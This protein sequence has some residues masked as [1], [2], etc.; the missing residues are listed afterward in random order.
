MALQDLLDPRGQPPHRL[1]KILAVEEKAFRFSR[2]TLTNYGNVA[3]VVVLDALRRA[4]D[5]GEVRRG[6]RAL[7][8]AFGPGITAAMAVG[9]W[10][11]DPPT[12]PSEYSRLSGATTA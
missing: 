6:D 4:F 12:A 2:A 3:S 10:T 11:S 7:I 1:G 9:T 5:S 8:A